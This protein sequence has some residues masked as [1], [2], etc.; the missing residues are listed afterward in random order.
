MSDRIELERNYWDVA[1]GEPDIFSFDHFLEHFVTFDRV[2]AV[3]GA[4]QDD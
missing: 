3:E 1:C 4:T 2:L